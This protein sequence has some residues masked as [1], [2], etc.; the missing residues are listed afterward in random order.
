MLEIIPADADQLTAAFVLPDTVE[1]NCC[2]CPEV[3]VAV[4]GETE[5]ETELPTVTVSVV[6]PNTPDESQARTSTVCV[7]VD[8]AR[9]VLILDTLVAL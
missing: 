9:Y 7:P 3:R 6:E 2:V 8:M 5:M 1:V 4:V